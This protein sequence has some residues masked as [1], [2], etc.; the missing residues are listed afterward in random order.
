MILD[1]QRHI[2]RIENGLMLSYMYLTR[3]DVCDSSQKQ[4]VQNDFQ[5]E[6]IDMISLNRFR[7]NTTKTGKNG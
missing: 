7:I 6:N 2:N 4:S 5:A 3:R 1:P